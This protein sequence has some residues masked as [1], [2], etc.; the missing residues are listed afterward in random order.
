MTEPDQPAEDEFVLMD[1]VDVHTKAHRATEHD[2]EAV[3]AGLY[4]EPRYGVYSG[5]EIA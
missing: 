2:E 4:G 5:Q 3:L 1:R